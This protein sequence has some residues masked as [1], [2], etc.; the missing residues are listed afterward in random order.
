MSEVTA[1]I[2][3]DIVQVNKYISSSKTVITYTAEWCGPCRRIKPLAIEHLVANGYVLSKSYEIAKTDFKQNVNDFIP[4][5]K[6][7]LNS[8]KEMEDPNLTSSIQTS[9]IEEFKTFEQQ[10]IKLE[11]FAF[12]E[13]F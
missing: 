8:D 9:D 7:V 1:V 5:F 11:P 10:G 12:N 13:D 3:K 4:F 6:M 2:N